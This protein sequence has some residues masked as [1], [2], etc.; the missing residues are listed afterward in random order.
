MKTT[1]EIRLEAGDVIELDVSG[2]PASALVLLA[3]QDTVIFD[4]CDGSM[5]LV[6]R[7][8]ELVNVRVFDGLSA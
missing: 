6:A 1:T 2:V 5:P 4:L 7:A 3:S 8:E